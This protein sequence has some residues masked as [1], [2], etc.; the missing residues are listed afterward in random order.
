MIDREFWRR[1]SDLGQRLLQEI[2]N[3]IPLFR[4]LILQT[5]THAFCLALAAA[6]T[7]AFFPACLVMLAVFR[8]VLRWQ[9][10]YDVLLMT[11]QSY[12]PVGGS[13]YFTGPLDRRITAMGPGVGLNSLLWVLLGAAGVFVPLETALNR[14]WKAKEDRPYWMNQIV[15]FSLTILCTLL[16]L[17]F[18]T[19]AGVLNKIIGFL[20]FIDVAAF[21]Q[22]VIVRV[23]MTC[24]LIASTC[25]LYKF[26][27]NAKTDA[28]KVLPAAILAGVMAELV[29]NVYLHA[30]P[31]LG[32]TQGPFATPVRFMLLAYFESFVMLGCA[33][34]A[35]QTE[36]YPWMG[37]L[38]RKRSGLPPQ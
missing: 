6:A 30:V 13:D 26:L 20:P 10:A 35:S 4:Y 8:N 37:F 25:A 7:L 14:L 22:Q 5:E 1:Q 11:I 17:V 16:G 21:L 27:P 19:V 2:K 33:F 18:L 31:Q 23:T 34:L 38:T 15:G 29:R 12:F 24:F 3:L 9:F 28:E 32:A 36:R